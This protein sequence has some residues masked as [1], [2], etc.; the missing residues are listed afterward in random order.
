VIAG[1]PANE[2]H[3]HRPCRNDAAK[4]VTFREVVYRRGKRVGG[5]LV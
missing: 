5:G 3:A 1:Y 4:N 2:F